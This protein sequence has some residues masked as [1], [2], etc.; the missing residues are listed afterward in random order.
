MA[1]RIGDNFFHSGK[2]CGGVSRNGLRHTY[3]DHRSSYGGAGHLSDDT[4]SYA[5]VA[6]LAPAP[7][8]ERR[9]G[10]APLRRRRPP[11]LS[12]P[13]SASS[14]RAEARRACRFPRATPRSPCRRRRPWAPDQVKTRSRRAG[15]HG[16]GGAAGGGRFAFG[17]ERLRAG[18]RLMATLGGVIA[19]IVGITRRTRP[20]T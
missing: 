17:V 16:S 4:D 18:D 3:R 1:K 19:P 11:S 6:Q 13:R 5:I 2:V 9:G 20:R 8:A 10:P 14:P 7:R 15:R 12:N